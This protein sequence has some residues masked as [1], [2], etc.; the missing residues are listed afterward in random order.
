[1]AE[2]QITNEI[3]RE[4]KAHEL[5]PGTVVAIRPPG[6]N[7]FITLW[8]GSARPTMVEFYSSEM[9]W[10][11]VNFVRPDGSI[12]DDQDRVVHVC[13]YLGKI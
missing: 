6:H 7:G 5:V 3:G 10:T 4:L 9:H 12:V 11:V 8:V 1:M 2:T 13:E